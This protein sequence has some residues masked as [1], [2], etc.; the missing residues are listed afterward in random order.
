[1]DNQSQSA[2]SDMPRPQTTSSSAHSVK[3]NSRLDKIRR[4]Y[5][6]V[7]IGCLLAAASIAIIAVLTGGFGEVLGRS[8]GTIA[9]VAVHALLGF[10]YLA[11]TEKFANST[12]RKTL[13]LFSNVV[14]GLITA[15]FITA[16]FGIWQVLDGQ[17]ITKL[18]LL[19]GVLLFA[20]LHAEALHQLRGYDSKVTQAITVNYGIMAVVVVML[21]VVIFA[22][23]TELLG[24]MFYRILA[25]VGIVDATLTITLAILHKLYI[26]KHPEV[27]QA[28][29]SVAAVKSGVSI[30]KVFV[31]LILILVALQVLGALFTLFWSF[32]NN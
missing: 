24:D 4:V 20:N 19:Y 23:D 17:L 30:G 25:A 10:N 14:F 22:Q 2:Q 12:E 11:G 8:L 32:G 13:E 27:A 16:V 5:F 1:M 9:V 21:A 28:S 3:L 18:Y 6:Q 31:W 26:Q 15:S 29:K 7:L